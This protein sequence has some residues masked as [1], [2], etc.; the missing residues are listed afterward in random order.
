MKDLPQTNK[1]NNY[2]EEERFWKDER[3]WLGHLVISSTIFTYGLRGSRVPQ[4]A[5]STLSRLLMNVAV[6]P[7]RRTDSSFIIFE[8]LLTL[9]LNNLSLQFKFGRSISS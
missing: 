8:W 3:H 5:S 9:S 7:M 4:L 2:S 6:L 1:M